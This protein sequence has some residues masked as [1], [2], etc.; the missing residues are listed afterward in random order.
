M[1]KPVKIEYPSWRYH[2]TL[3]AMVIKNEFEEPDVEEGW[4][5]VPY[6]QTPKVHAATVQSANSTPAPPCQECA[7]K[8]KEFKQKEESFDRAWTELLADKN[9]LQKRYETLVSEFKAM[10]VVSPKPPKEPKA[11]QVEAEVLPVSTGA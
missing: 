4:R 9:A 2:P 11:K 7:R 10:S 8:D 5:D 3:P 6:P 1:N